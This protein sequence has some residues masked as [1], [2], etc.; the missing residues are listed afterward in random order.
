MFEA[1][2]ATL[3]PNTADSIL[4]LVHTA[5][6]LPNIPKLDKF[7]IVVPVYASAFIVP[8]T[9]NL[10]AGAGVPMPKLPLLS[11]NV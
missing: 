2:T 4:L 1:L 9:S 8:L 5:V 3:E 10:V 11:K 7:V 6:L